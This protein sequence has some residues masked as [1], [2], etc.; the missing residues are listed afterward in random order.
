M[1][2][3]PDWLIWCCAGSFL[4]WFVSL[5]KGGNL[6]KRGWEESDWKGHPKR[7]RWYRLLGITIILIAGFAM[8]LAVGAVR[9]SGQDYRNYQ[10]KPSHHR[11]SSR[12]PSRPTAAKV[13][14]KN[15][16]ANVPRRSLLAM[17][18]SARDLI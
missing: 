14:R 8:V 15:V 16:V 2:R 6:V 11:S 18:A 9:M 17:D 13:A 3:P 4:L 1:D 10:S 7:G 12:I 5:W